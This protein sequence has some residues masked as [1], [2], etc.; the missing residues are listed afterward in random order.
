M[1]REKSIMDKLKEKREKDEEKGIFVC[2]YCNGTGKE[3]NSYKGHTE[4]EDCIFCDGRGKLIIPEVII[5]KIK[6]KEREKLLKKQLD[7]LESC[8]RCSNDEVKMSV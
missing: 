4:I 3:T 2:P 7:I 1:N 8:G 5:E 6:R